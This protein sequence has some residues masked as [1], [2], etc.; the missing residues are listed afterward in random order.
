[1]AGD[2]IPNFALDM[3]QSLCSQ[4]ITLAHRRWAVPFPHSSDLGP[5]THAGPLVREP[6]SVLS[7]KLP[8]AKARPRVYL[9]KRAAIFL[10]TGLFA[11]L[12][13]ARPNPQ[14]SCTAKSHLK[15]G[16]HMGSRTYSVYAVLH[17]APTPARRLG[18]C[19][20]HW[21]HVQLDPTTAETC[22]R[23]KSRCRCVQGTKMSSA[24][25]LP[26]LV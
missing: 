8:I 10:L 7:S 26:C 12:F 25:I 19:L 11:T 15:T 16:Q 23:G 17:R 5:N 21:S 18:Q 1:M 3:Y 14:A 22:R 4:D 2:K 20:P 24:G 9:L 6:G 13:C